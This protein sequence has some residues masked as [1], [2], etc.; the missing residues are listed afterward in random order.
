MIFVLP[1]LLLCFVIFMY[2]VYFLARDDFVIIRKDISLER[3]F[4]MAILTFFVSML[5][6][7]F[8]YALFYFN[9]GFLNP[10]VFFDLPYFPGLSLPGGVVGGS[11]F[12]Y[13]YSS[14]KKMPFGRLFDIFMMA[15]IGVL[16]IGLIIGYFVYLGKTSLFFNIIL[17]FSILSFFLFTKLIFPYSSRG[18][19]KEGSLGLVFISIFSFIYFISKLLLNV[20]TFS[21]IAPENIFLL[22]SLFASLILIINQE[23]IDKYISRK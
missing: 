20:K 1:I 11:L 3:I 8:F 7:R 18:E 15:F 14:F 23:I 16:P 2:F 10:L 19:I 9:P 12:A 5:F 4:S 17:V 6:A 13:F 21:F 22:V